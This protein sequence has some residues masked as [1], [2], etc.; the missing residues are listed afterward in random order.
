MSAQVSTAVNGNV[1]FVASSEVAAAATAAGL[2]QPTVD[3]LVDHY[4]DAQLRALKTGLLAAAAIALATLLFTA[5]LPGERPV[6]DDDA[7]VE[8]ATPS[9]T[10]ASSG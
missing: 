9:D 2:D 4:E 3:V 5:G 8:P 7:G 1:S 10:A 6:H